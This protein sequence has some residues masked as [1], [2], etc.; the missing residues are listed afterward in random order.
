MKKLLS[1]LLVWSTL[2]CCSCAVQP[3]AE[4]AEEPL[5]LYCAAD[6]ANASGGDAITAVCVDWDT[7]PRGD[8]RAQA[9]AIMELLMGACREEGFQSPIPAG[10]KLQSCE[11]NG[12][13]AVVDFS[14]AYE[15]ISGIQLTIADYCVALSLTQLESIYAVRIT[16]N[17]KELSYR[18]TNRFLAGDV[19]LTSMED[20]V[21]TMPVQLFFPDGSGQ[22]GQEERLLNVFEGESRLNAV[23]DA[24]L[25]GP[26]TEDL[27]VLLPEGFSVSAAWL[28]ENVCYLNLPSENETLLPQDHA[29]QKLL[30]QGLVNSLCS[31]ENVQTVQIL[32]DGNA[33]AAFGA[34][35]IS[36]PLEAGEIK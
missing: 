5:R 31:V 23:V 16:V 6:L 30:M 22:L 18:D 24:L 26:E 25:E 35:D 11:L 28:E 7:L 3:T 1:L 10:T 21:R 8:E 15:Q 17:G 9:Q 27:Q 20:V 14:S 32:I 19:L 29:E 12:G 34:V 13:V 4:N 2:L 33:A 36:Q